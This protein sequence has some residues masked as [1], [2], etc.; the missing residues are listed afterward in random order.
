MAPTLPTRPLGK[1]GPQVTALGFGMMGLSFMY[2]PVPSDEERLQFLDHVYESG[3][4]FWD[5]SDLYGD[6]EA[7]LGKWFARSGKRE[8][9]FLASKFGFVTSGPRKGIRSDPDYV[10]EACEKSLKTMGVKTIDLYYVHRVDMKTP[11]EETVEAMVEL[12]KEGKITYLGLSEVS[13]E[14]VRRAHKV[15]PISAVQIEYSPFTMDIESPSTGL[16]STCRE[17]GIAI[18][19]YA[20]LG[21]GILSGT[22]KS[23]DDFGPTDY[24]KYLPRFSK[25]NFVKNSELVDQL[26]AVADEKGVPVGTLTLAWVMAQGEEIIPI[27]GTSKA[28]HFDENMMALGVQ[29]TKEENER[30][31]AAVNHATIAGDRYDPNS[32]KIC[33]ADT[34][35]PK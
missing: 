17:L 14:T 25:D 27:P 33:F 1:D 6:S 30:I 23:P 35:L 16:L 29:I 34:P 4:R 11:I 10:K 21:R 15:H 32:M 13:S 22:I 8:E 2:G 7:L 28:G 5:T 26:K 18:V 9:I 24:R 3:Q 20:P 12:K 19:A 31:R